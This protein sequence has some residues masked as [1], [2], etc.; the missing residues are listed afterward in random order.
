MDF[1]PFIKAGLLQRE[2]GT[3]I[4]VCRA[5]INRW[6]TGA[7]NPHHLIS[8]RVS[9]VIARVEAAVDEGELPLDP[10]FPKADRQDKLEEILSQYDE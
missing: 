1:S 7:T 6:Y 4:G 5:T 8:S 3:L 9:E 10:D 2:A